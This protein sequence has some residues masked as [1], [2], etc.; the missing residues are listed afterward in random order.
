MA[1]YVIKKEWSNNMWWWY[2]YK[3]TGWWIFKTEKYVDNSLS[4]V[5]AEECESNLR[6]ELEQCPPQVVKEIEI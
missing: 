4:K 3:I 5:S 1:K 6:Q 2:A